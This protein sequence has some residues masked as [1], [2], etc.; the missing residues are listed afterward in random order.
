MNFS[1]YF[2]LPF[3]KRRATEDFRIDPE[4]MS[5]LGSGYSLTQL[6]AVKN[7]RSTD[8]SPTPFRSAFKENVAKSSDILINPT[9][10][11]MSSTK[12][13]SFLQR[14]KYDE[15]CRSNDRT[16]V[17][18]FV[19]TSPKVMDS[20][21]K[22]SSII[23][24]RILNSLST[25]ASPK[26]EQSLRRSHPATS[27]LLQRFGVSTE[28]I[29]EAA[30][31]KHKFAKT[32]ATPTVP[33]KE[34]IQPEKLEVL[35]TIPEYSSINEEF[36]FRAA[37]PLNILM[38]TINDDLDTQAIKFAFSPAGRKNK[39]MVSKTTDL[40]ENETINFNKP[41][42]IWTQALPAIPTNSKFLVPTNIKLPTIQMNES[43]RTSADVTGLPKAD[44]LWTKA[45]NDDK[46]KCP[47]CLVPNEKSATKCVSCETTLSK[48]CG[49]SLWESASKS[50]KVKCPSCM[51]PNDKLATKCVSCEATLSSDTERAMF[52]SNPF[53]VSTPLQPSESQ[54]Q[55]FTFKPAQSL[56]VK[57]PVSSSNNL[58]AM[59]SKKRA[60]NGEVSS[61][62]TF[63]H[64]FS[65]PKPFTF[66]TSAVDQSSQVPSGSSF[67]L[68]AVKSPVVSTPSFAVN[69]TA[70]Q[71]QNLSST[72]FTST[73]PSFTF[74]GPISVL[75]KNEANLNM[76]SSSVPPHDSKVIPDTKGPF[77]SHISGLATADVN[78]N[79][80]PSFSFGKRTLEKS[81][82]QINTV[83]PAVS[84]ATGFS[85][86]G[87]L[88]NP[89][90]FSSGHEQN[91]TQFG[92]GTIKDQNSLSSS[93]KQNETSSINSINTAIPAVT[94]K[95]TF[96]TGFSNPGSLQSISTSS[97]STGS[98]LFGAAR[99]E[100]TN[101]TT[102]GA[103][104]NDNKIAP[105]TPF[106]FGS[107]AGGDKKSSP[108]IFGAP[109]VPSTTNE[110]KKNPTPFI[111]GTITAE[112]GEKTS[113]FTFVT[114]D[115][116]HKVI[117]TGKKT[118]ALS[119]GT[120]SETFS[121]GSNNKSQQSNNSL[122]VSTPLFGSAMTDKLPFG[123]TTSNGSESPNSAM[124]MGYNSGDGSNLTAAVS[125]SAAPLQSFPSFANSLVPSSTSNFGFNSSTSSSGIA[126]GN[127]AASTS[128]STAAPFMFSGGFGA[129]IQQ[130]LAPDLGASS[131][132][133]FGAAPFGNIPPT[134]PSASFS[135]GSSGLSNQQQ[136]N[137]GG[138]F[139]LGSSDNK[140][141]NITN[142]RRKVKVKRPQ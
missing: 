26:D 96:G 141:S 119:F 60:A 39:I 79:N 6:K 52:K 61:S 73:A 43:M 140:Q 42:L 65:A 27:T 28:T 31:T 121:F 48:P 99:T 85:F 136:Q 16:S 51:V 74:G 22:A 78:S 86:G 117:D 127:S 55:G 132:F 84:S 37:K 95:P 64:P 135:G 124:D 108:F 19:K 72:T 106:M 38:S 17:V 33:K 41:T 83:Q 29:E 125:M 13:M 1:Q 97:S 45:L 120:T 25:L 8:P 9:R 138:L 35:K 128:G 133:S 87:A 7:T 98:F 18:Q 46:L 81:D 139:S 15:K 2:E 92:L 68:G 20:D 89:S 14:R 102:A 104:T 118:E 101:S 12:T 36:A 131:S 88:S 111:F 75:G 114:N 47:S 67:T 32:Q 4:P 110:D 112:N 66:G 30:E 100:N 123:V 49:V 62:T 130:N 103:S 137:A 134:N 77:G 11:S 116:K 109:A 44:S 53:S 23:A 122:T 71:S 21:S 93:L 142:G 70:L 24:K 94:E 63:N 115:D 3:S 82:A 107:T 34:M 10:Q 113:T 58:D 76:F 129:G 105:P 57:P 126:F 5:I 80:I 91:K 59:P 50:D 90:S 69:E 56:D 40:N 54:F